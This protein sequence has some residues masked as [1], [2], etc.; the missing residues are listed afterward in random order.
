MN[1]RDFLKAAVAAPL[2]AALPA[3]TSLFDGF[4]LGAMK[5]YS[6]VGDPKMLAAQEELNGMYYTILH[7]SQFVSLR[8]YA[9]RSAWEDRWRAYRIALRNGGPEKTPRQ[10]M[11]DWTQ[12]T[13]LRGETG[14]WHG[15][16]IMQS[17][18]VSV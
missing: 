2:T 3:H 10:I 18:R 14:A 9:A 12:P 6:I 8:E 16:R 13:P 7:H 15:M 17:E 1:R 11:T 5:A 4:D